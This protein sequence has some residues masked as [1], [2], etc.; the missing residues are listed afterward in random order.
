[1][2]A[3]RTRLLRS[4]VQRLRIVGTLSCRAQPNVH[5]VRPISVISSQL[6]SVS[7]TSTASTSTISTLD[8]HDNSDK[9]SG[10]ATESAL[11]D[12]ATDAFT[13][14]TVL[15]EAKKRW[16]L[17]AGS[18]KSTTSPSAAAESPL[19]TPPSKVK[20]VYPEGRP[21]IADLTRRMLENRIL[22]GHT[23]RRQQQQQQ[24][25]DEARKNTSIASTTTTG[26]QGSSPSTS[27]SSPNPH[28]HRAPR[29]ADGGEVEVEVPLW[30]KHRMAIKAKTGGQV[31]NPQRK[32]TRQSM[33]EV[34]YLR[35]Q[36]PDEWTTPKLAEHFNVSGES[37]AK[38]LRTNYQPSPERAAQQD[39]VRLRHRKEN[40]SADIARFK[41]ERKAE[42][43]AQKTER[44]AEWLARKTEREAGW[45]ARKTERRA[46]W[47]AG[48]AAERGT[49]QQAKAKAEEAERLRQVAESMSPEE[50]ERI[51]NQRHAAWLA[52]KAERK[53]STATSDAEIKLGAP[54]KK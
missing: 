31:W 4:G 39:E 16:G 1:M 20:V 8:K 44:Q 40:I 14:P 42:W 25:I 17:T 2:L 21:E 38:I 9:L 23:G 10:I 11:E 49:Q 51:K 33:E 53:R 35:K 18:A 24:A 37:I 13:N 34:R 36:F 19:P 54:K 32:L 22:G 5:S 3:H 48:Q 27:S 28:L 47:L 6:M 43:E 50:Y 45:L 46:A 41:A 15:Q 7:T 26:M 52:R 30:K 29:D 12:L